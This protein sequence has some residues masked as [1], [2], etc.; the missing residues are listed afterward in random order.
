MRA[1]LAMV[2]MPQ[3]RLCRIDAK[4]LGNAFANRSLREVGADLQRSAGEGFAI[5]KAEI[6]VRIRDRR[7]D[8]TG[9]ITGGTRN[10]TRAVRPNLERAGRIEPGDAAAA[11]PDFGEIDGRDSEQIAAALH[12]AMADADLAADLVLRRARDLSVLD[13]SRL[14]RGPAH[15]KGH[16]VMDA[17]APGQVMH[18]GHPGSGTGFDDVD[19]KLAG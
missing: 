14:G 10:R 11:G 1:E 16:R 18:P 3:G 4:R 13:E 5:G 6:H 8:P 19:G 2:R 9:V 7:L 12:Q 17:H 15:V